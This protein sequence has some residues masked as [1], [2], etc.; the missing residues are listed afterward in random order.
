MMDFSGSNRGYIFVRY[1]NKEDAKRA[2]KELN[3]YEVYRVFVTAKSP[4]YFDY[5]LSTSNVS[6]GTNLNLRSTNLFFKEYCYS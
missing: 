3:N 4:E 6:W 1:T 2:V 5:R